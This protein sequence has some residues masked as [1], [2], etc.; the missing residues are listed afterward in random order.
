MKDMETNLHNRTSGYDE[1][2]GGVDGDTNAQSVF[3]GL[4][5]V[6]ASGNFRAVVCSSD[7]RLDNRHLVLG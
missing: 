4:W 1:Y 7:P 3:E 5:H 2:C 6:L